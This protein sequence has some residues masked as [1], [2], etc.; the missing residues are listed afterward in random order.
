MVIYLL[1]EKKNP[2]TN[3]PLDFSS[4]ASCDHQP[5]V[6]VLNIP[7]AC[8]RPGV[9]FPFLLQLLRVA[10]S[11]NATLCLLKAGIVPWLVKKKNAN[12]GRWVR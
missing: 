11:R 7:L 4:D 5:Q 10:V 3:Q 2:Q 8:Q 9:P 12:S 1:G 6:P